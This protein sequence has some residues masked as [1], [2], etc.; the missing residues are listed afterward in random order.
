[1]GLLDVGAYTVAIPLA[2]I[3]SGSRFE[4]PAESVTELSGFRLVQRVSSLMLFLKSLY[5]FASN[6]I[7]RSTHT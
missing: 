5:R 4:R 1:M 6:K 7:H 3:L 2:K